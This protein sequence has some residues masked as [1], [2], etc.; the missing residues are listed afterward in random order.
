MTFHLEMQTKKKIVAKNASRDQSNR[1]SCGQQ[2]KMASVTEM[3]VTEVIA[4][5]AKKQRNVG[6]LQGKSNDTQGTRI[7]NTNYSFSQ[8]ENKDLCLA[9]EDS[10]G[11]K[12]SEDKVA[13]TIFSPTYHLPKD[14]CGDTLDKGDFAVLFRNK[15]H[16]VEDL[17]I[18]A[19][20]FRPANGNQQDS[21]NN[22]AK[23]TP[24]VIKE[25]DIL[26][27]S[28]DDSDK[29]HNHSHIFDVKLNNANSSFDE[30][31][32]E[33]GNISTEVSEIYLAMQHSKLECIDESN[34]ETVTTNSCATSDEDGEYDDF[35]P[36]LFMKNLP[37]LRSVVPRFRP[38]LLPKQTR[39]CPSTSLVLDLD[40]TLV[41]STL[42][43]CENAD[44]TIPINFNM[45]DQTI[46]VRCRPHLKEF[47]ERVSTLFE[48]IIFTASQSIY[49]EKLLNVLD[50]QKKLFRH[51]VY[52]ESCVY[53]EGN[54]LKDLSV[55][56]RDLARVIIIDN[57]PQAFGFQVDNGIPIES[58]FDDRTDRELPLLLPFLESLVGVDDV[59]PLIAKKFNLRERIAAA[60]S[61]N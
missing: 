60:A 31:C 20:D 11:S 7:I 48:I 4:S 61:L 26:P 5:S 12:P 40:E 19:M 18:D 25:S 21:A 56:G 55:L 35:N 43:P 14:V 22:T 16:T 13:E 57:S 58:W 54:F 6:I 59:R 28:F 50:P 51:R 3:K 15:D 9:F 2:K 44:F 30:E 53:V 39:S 10:H 42:E 27:R 45:R 8:V 1:K 38:M 46:Y 49:A 29:Q 41:H 34:P 24:C 47:V 37:D 17:K 23:V 33:L 32:T 52:R 36:F